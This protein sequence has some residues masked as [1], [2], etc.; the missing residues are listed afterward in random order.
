MPRRYAASIFLALALECGAAGAFGGDATLTFISDPSWLASSAPPDGSLGDPWGGAQCICFS[1]GCPCCWTGN[2]G[3]IPGACWV[4][5]PGTTPSTVPV[6]LEWMYLSKTIDVPGYPDGGVLYFAADD[7]AELRVNGAV[8][9]TIGSVTD[10]GAAAGAQA[11]LTQV[12]LTAFVQPGPN[13]IVVR[14]QNGPGWFTGTDCNPCNFG[15]NPTGVILGG[16]ISYF[17]ATPN[18]GRSWGRLKAIYR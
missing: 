10:Y 8:V 9:R 4:W 14:L 16:T 11:Q 2:I 12:D 18:E 6:D 5:K 13:E 17:A 15:Q 1:V 7:F 3:A